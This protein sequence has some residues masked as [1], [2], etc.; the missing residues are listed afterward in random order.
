V[1]LQ[2]LNPGASRCRWQPGEG[3]KV[4]RSVAAD[5]WIELA[6]GELIEL[7]LAQSS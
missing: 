2:L 5:D 3:W 7:R 4:G 6:P 1:V